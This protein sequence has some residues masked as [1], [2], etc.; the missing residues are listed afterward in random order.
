M[1]DWLKKCCVSYD[2]I[3]LCICIFV[4]KGANDLLLK[5]NL[6][7]ILYSI[8]F[9]IIFGAGFFE[10]AR[11]AILE[12]DNTN[13]VACIFVLGI[14]IYL[15]V[16]FF[17]KEGR[18]LDLFQKNS[19]FSGLLESFFVLF[20]CAT[21][22]FLTMERGM[23][24]ALL[25]VILLASIYACARLLGGRLCGSFAIVLGFFFVLSVANASFDAQEYMNCLCFLIPYAAFLFV[26]QCIAKTFAKSGFVL[27]C[28]DIVLGIIF[29]IAIAINPFVCA[30]LIGCICALIFGVSKEEQASRLTKGPIASIIIVVFTVAFY[31]GCNYLIGNLS[32]LPSLDLDP[33]LVAFRGWEDLLEFFVLKY[34]KAIQYIYRPFTISFFP[35]LMMFLGCVSGYYAIRKKSSGIGPFCLTYLILFAYYMMCNEVGTHFYYLT[36]FLPIFGA[37]GIYG[38][39]YSDEKRQEEETIPDEILQQNEK[40]YIPEAEPVIQENMEETM[41]KEIQEDISLNVDKKD[42]WETDEVPEWT[43]S[44]DYFSGQ[45]EKKEEIVQEEETAVDTVLEQK[46]DEERLQTIIEKPVEDSENPNMIHIEELG[47]ESLSTDKNY[48]IDSPEILETEQVEDQKDNAYMSDTNGLLDEDSI[49]PEQADLD[50]SIQTE[51]EDAKL[52]N[53]LERLDISDNIR[54]MKESATEDMADVIEREEEQDELLTAIPTEEID[55]EP[56]N[57]VYTPESYMDEEQVEEPKKDGFHSL[58]KYVKPDFDFSIEPDSQILSNNTEPAISEYDRVPTI[59]DLERKWRELNGTNLA[60]EESVE[61]ADMMPEPEPDVE[62]IPDVPEPEPDVELSTDIP[63]EEPA[64]T[65]EP[66][67]SG[68]A[69]SLDDVSKTLEEVSTRKEPVIHSEE[70]VKRTATGKRSYHRITLG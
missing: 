21:M 51:D 47:S 49:L 39:L 33:R 10:I 31:V 25:I 46:A 4:Q 63:E 38:T 35:A 29:S 30:L 5:R 65:V 66:E 24:H 32:L 6:L 58:P 42:S 67:E 2:F 28:S 41:K 27:F 53:L 3:V 13:I 11:L 9:V 18:Y 14:A 17:I 8:L 64:V 20:L 34:T 70:V 22:F 61:Q 43:I 23:D 69:Y 1:K 50:I 60:M 16:A 62:L 56:E 44:P 59:N 48:V 26:T 19:L 40:M 52:D 57:L 54:R 12:T 55:F 68:F 45:S 15:I 37:Y 36:Y 7:T